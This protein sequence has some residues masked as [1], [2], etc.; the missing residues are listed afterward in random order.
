MDVPPGLNVD[1]ARLRPSA[2]ATVNVSLGLGTVR[3][4]RRSYTEAKPDAASADVQVTTM[5]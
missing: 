2:S 4:P 5:D 1:P 3:P